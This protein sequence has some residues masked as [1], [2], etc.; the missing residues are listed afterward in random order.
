MPGRIFS[1]VYIACIILPFLS[2]SRK[3]NEAADV[4]FQ[5]LPS[6]ETGISFINKVEDNKAL[7][8]FKY[9][10][11]YN[12]GGVAIGDINNDGKPDIF[13]TANQHEN[14]LYI[15]HGNWKFE[16]ITDK[17]GIKSMHQWHTGVTMVDINGDGWLDIY[18]CNSGEYPGD[19]RS[20]ELYINQK[21]GTFK[22]EA[23]AYGL[24]DKGQST[25]A[26]FFDYDHDGDLDCFVLN[27]SNRSVES[28][29]YSSQLRS[30]RD[31]KNG[32]HL[33]RNDGGK[34]VDV[35]SEAAIYGSEIGFGLGVTVG[36]VN[37][38]G[39]EDIYVSNDYFER[40]YLYINQHNGTFREVIDQAMG[41][42]S[43]GS[44]GSDMV[45]INN[46]GWLDIFTTEMLPENDYRLKTT[47]KFDDYDV[48]NAKNQMDYHHQF[49]SNC[50]QLNN[51]D[52]TFSEIAQFAGVDA[53]N[54]SWG[55]LSFDF[56]NDG[57]KDIFVCNGISKDLTNQDF[58]EFF[59][60]REMREQIAQRGL[61]YDDILKI[62]PSEPVYKCAFVNQKN[63]VFKNETKQLGFTKPAFS[64]GA[65]YGDLDGDGDVDLV[66]NNENSEA[67]VYRNMTSEKLHH[68]FLKIS[69]KGIS[70]NTFGLGARLTLY[71]KGKQQVL[72][73]MPSRGFESSVDPVLN[74]GMGDD[75]MADSLV[76]QWP[77]GK[78]QSLI[79]V[80]ADTTMQLSQ[81]N[82]V[83]IFHDSKKI[84]N[85]L[86]VNVTNT[87]ISGNIRHRENE[88]I[89]FNVERLMPKMIST[90]GP[91]LAVGDVNGDGL[92]D[93]YIGSS[94]DDTAKLF[95]QQRDGH[96]VQKPQRAFIADKYFENIGA[97]FF[98]ADH[99]GDLDLV[100]ASG[101][102]EAKQG[103]PYL[104]QRLYI[105][106]GKGNFTRA[107]DGWPAVSLNASC[108]RICE[109]KEDG[110]QLIFIGA[111]NVPGSYGIVP[112][113]VLLQGNG[114]GIFTDVTADL[115]PDLLKLGM[116]TDAQWADI[117]GDGIK[118]LIV[119]GDWMPVTIFKYLQGKL[120][121]TKSLNNSSGW[122]NCL[123]VSDINQDGFPDLIA[124]NWGLNSRIKAD[125]SHPAKLYVADFAKNGRT[126][127]IPVYYK[128]DGKA[129]PYFMKG[130]IQSDIPQL[131]KKFLKFSGYAGKG[132]EEIFTPEELK[133]ATVLTVDQT[134]TA[135]FMNDGKG[136]F[137]MEP[138]PSR[139][140]FSPV[141]GMI[142]TDLNGDGL[143]DL[144]LGGNFYGVK[145]QTGRFD[146]SYG[147]TFLADARFHYHYAEPIESGLFING[148]ARD[149]ATIKMADGKNMIIV[150]MN[151]DNLYLFKQK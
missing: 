122:W 78:Y 10:N 105:N 143:K 42:I 140:Q 5:L 41:H 115:A 43:Q 47:I 21:D 6:S 19:D 12:G 33:Y 29:G 76:V 148:E 15:N 51:K 130:E 80:R 63:L 16:D 32:D 117:E 113:S 55:A 84:I 107:A 91:K 26:I 37:N 119:V 49:T 77:G 94:I 88:F 129:Y 81:E 57:W 52:G 136:N 65:A 145:P 20:N 108:V 149:I 50:L 104:L 7:N 86:F 150:A 114:H 35:S 11:F 123:T 74:F 139:A 116:V 121:K 30:I 1:V 64:N 45:D 96:F 142:C 82:A 83:Q 124:G 138:L 133:Q 3:S 90:E 66:V 110:R 131:K 79:H 44:M 68:H 95:I 17:A 34:F 132:I 39:W 135:V 112:A 146:A 128:T 25:Q 109:F 73:Q 111:R 87:A 8:I 100:V 71:V 9:R 31:P 46:D 92:E 24:D 125:S 14:R 22:E 97:A 69:L 134:Q 151:N 36:D 118:E 144:F 98:D 147:T 60:S 56:D 40:D 72:E 93:F 58:L 54:W 23:H 18:V 67:F 13:F 126:A 48:V 102:N 61:N 62:M 137:T 27:N 59:G 106:D 120:Q 4:L 2:C 99:D 141:F 89:D 53:S 101:G 103:S 85:P 127:C 38:D 70:P 28:F 75:D